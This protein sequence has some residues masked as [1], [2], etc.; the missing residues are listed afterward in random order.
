MIWTAFRTPVQSA[1]PADEPA[2]HRSRE[3]CKVTHLESPKQLLPLYQRMQLIRSCEEQL[4]R[5][6]QRGLVHGAC[7]TYVGQEA[8]AAGVCSHLRP[9]DVVFSTHRGHGHAL[10]KGMPPRELFAE[11][12][13]R[14]TGCSRGRGGSMHL[15]SP[16]IG[17]MGTSGIVGPCILQAAGAGYTFKLLK[18]DRVAVA[19]FGDGAVNNGA[20]HEG[21]NLAAIWKLPVLF[22]CENNQFATEVPFAYAA[23]N[24]GVA[25]RGELYGLTGYEVDGND[26]EAVYRVA[27]EAVRR[28]RTGGGPTLL[29][30][31]TYRTRAHAEGMGD[32]TYRTKEEVEDWKTRCPIKRLRTRLADSS[33]EWARIDANISAA[34]ADAQQFA[35]SSPWPDPATATDHVF[36]DSNPPVSAAPPPGGREVTWTQAAHEA[37]SAAM[38]RDP[39]IF[40]LGEGIGKRGGNFKTTAGLYER[41]GPERLCDTPISE[42]G[43]TGLACGA[44]MTGARP[45]VDFMFADFV[46]DGVGEVLNQ[47]AK[48]Q[49]MSS[50]RLRMPVLLRGCVGIGHSAATHHSGNYYPM[51]AH[52]PGLRV[53][54]PSTPYDAKGLLARALTCN[55]P[56]L[57]FE[58]RELL[59]VKG[60]VPQED[61]QIEFGKAVVAREGKDLTVVA[62]AHIARRTLE[63]CERLAQRGISVEVI[64]P[65]TVAPLD[66]QTIL[67]SVR[68]TGRLLVVDEAFAPFGL[69]AEVAACVIDAGF[70]DLDAP[71]RRLHGAFTPTPYSPTLEKAVV[72]QVEDIERAILALLQE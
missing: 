8:I 48:M 26:V 70:D 37:L 24:P 62:L 54:V 18:R 56:V 47:I 17:L 52:F 44:A 15:F 58:H 19:F 61:Y 57:F 35:E 29:E 14:Q 49:Y 27:G 5:S 72:P 10:A 50:G 1:S 7:H 2:I 34:V 64:D 51:Y 13:G 4:A 42:R 25:G 63:V 16:E 33:G 23:G 60:P 68:K 46:L 21:L 41:F 9:D 39:A 40:V 31:K 11:L 32:F 6:H 12:F 30:C 45:V 38:A 28:A 36:S 65:R 67:D 69:G 59:G 71:I 22:V 55:D 20:F 43:F 3:A 66:R 53:V